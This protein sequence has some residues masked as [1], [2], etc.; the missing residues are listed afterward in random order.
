MRP[1]AGEADLPLIADLLRALPESARHRVDL[2]RRLASPAGET[3]RDAILWLGDDGALVG[4]AAWQLWWAVLDWFAR[5]GPSQAEVEA[6]IF[7]WA[8]T[9]FRELDAARGRPLPD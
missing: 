3:G 1:V 8:P 7:A 5:P 6:A 9:R 2:P 4:L